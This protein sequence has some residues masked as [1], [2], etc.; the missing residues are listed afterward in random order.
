MRRIEEQYQW[1]KIAV[2]IENAYFEIMGWKARPASAKKPS[3]VA[4][5]SDAATAERRAG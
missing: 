3:A 1:Q 5:R 4:V 2:D